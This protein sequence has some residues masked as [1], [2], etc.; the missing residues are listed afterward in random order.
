M[1]LLAYLPRFR[2]AAR[3]M[4]VLEAR[5]DWSREQIA[6]YQLER[7]NALWA[8]AARRTPYYRAL[9]EGKTLPERFCSLDEYRET[10]PVLS[11]KT[12]AQD[13]KAFLAA[14]APRGEWHR[15]SGS[16][17][18]PLSVFR[19]HDDH[20]EMLRARYRFYA[21]WG[22]EVFDRVA[23]VWSSH[24]AR[25]P[26]WKGF[27]QRTQQQARDRLRQRLWIPANCLGDGDLAT[28][29]RRIGR[30]RPRGMYGFSRAVHLLAGKA[31]EVNFRCDSLRAVF[32][33]GEAAPAYLA[34]AVQ[35]A[36]QAPAV[37]EYG[38][39]DCG[40]IAGQG[41]D[42]A[43]RVRED[44]VLLETQPRDDGLYDLL[45]TP[46]TSSAF[47]L[48]RYKIG[49]L[50]HAPLHRPER[51]FAVLAGVAGRNDDLLRTPAGRYVHAACI[52]EVFELEYDSL[53]RRYRVHQDAHGEVTAQVEFAQAAAA[54]M[55]NLGQR[56]SHLLDGHPVRVEAVETIPQTAAGK[57]RLVTSELSPA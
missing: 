44:L 31:E 34:A 11:K 41:R 9:C 24:H 7:L 12:I 50:S 29:L 3:Q 39:V 21:S 20:R 52:D 32:L 25:A 54:D 26:G 18:A 38:S 2:E 19:A 45:V 4:A 15:T 42:G 5:E 55:T 33:T 57:H 22:V 10:V 30:F 56:L 35:R 17:G 47:P 8:S 48:L 53:V 40:F 49:D 6:A 13:R 36:F 46:L 43:L 16:T 23:W 37:A 27:F 14:G 51:G 1:T 28:H